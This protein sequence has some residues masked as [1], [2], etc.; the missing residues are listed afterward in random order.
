[1]P[2]PPY[3]SNPVLHL[4]VTSVFILA[5]RVSAY[6]R[7]PRAQAPSY[8]ALE[9]VPGPVKEERRRRSVIE[10]WRPQTQ[11]QSGPG[12]KGH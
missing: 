6:Q 3:M 12:E 2:V 10:G 1:M 4:H 5:L 7:R 11:S 9:W 8:W